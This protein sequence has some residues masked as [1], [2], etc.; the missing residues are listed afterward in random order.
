MKSIY[1]F[2]NICVIVDA[3]M[4]I[5]NWFYYLINFEPKPKFSF[6]FVPILKS[7]ST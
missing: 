2:H 7:I 6:D 3:I 4:L 1:L 5:D